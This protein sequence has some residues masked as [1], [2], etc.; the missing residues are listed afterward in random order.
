MKKILFYF[1]ILLVS[2]SCKPSTN[3]IAT[4]NSDGSINFISIEDAEK[5]D[6]VEGKLFVVDMYTDWCGWCKRMD[7]QTFGDP[8]VQKFLGE[9][10]YV[11]K[12][13]AEQKE[14]ITFRGKTYEWVKAGRSG[15]NTLAQ[16]LMGGRL[17]YP[18]M[19][20]LDENLEKIESKP[21]YKRQDQFLKDLEEIL[22][23]AKPNHES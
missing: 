22:A 2:F 19:V 11:I 18:T 4:T 7:K 13:N 14:P 20:Y 10:F 17:S 15:V 3:E 6:N 1:S 8:D 23:K 9:H 12:M 5:M 21:G 16:E